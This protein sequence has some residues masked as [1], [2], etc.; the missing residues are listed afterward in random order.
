MRRKH[1]RRSPVLPDAGNVITLSQKP[2]LFA[3]GPTDP[4]IHELVGRRIP[5]FP[6]Y[7]SISNPKSASPCSCGPSERWATVLRSFNA[8]YS[9]TPQ[10]AVIGSHLTRVRTT[11]D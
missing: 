8:R 6:V 4:G 3:V 11:Q 5:V 7:L 1:E 2:S 10:H 9:P